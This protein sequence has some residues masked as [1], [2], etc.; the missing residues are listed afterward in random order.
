MKS[1]T[2][3]KCCKGFAAMPEKQK[4]AICRMGGLAVAKKKGHMAR[5]GAIGGR[6][7]G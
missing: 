2:K 4:L 7:K 5:I 3:P 6:A 1:K